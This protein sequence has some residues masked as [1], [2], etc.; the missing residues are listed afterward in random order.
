MDSSS[1]RKRAKRGRGQER[2]ICEMISRARRN[3]RALTEAAHGLEAFG[4]R[5][6][7]VYAALAAAGRDPAGDGLDEEGEGEG[8]GEGEAEDVGEENEGGEQGQ[9]GGGGRGSETCRGRDPGP[10]GARVA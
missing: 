10:A 7:A 3:A 5:Y 2:R 6:A 4:R 8:E 9:C 1:S